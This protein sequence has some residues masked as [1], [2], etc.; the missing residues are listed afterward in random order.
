MR[1]FSGKD[2]K[3]R[4]RT[5]TTTKK[6]SESEKLT[7]RLTDLIN[8]YGKEAFFQDALLRDNNIEENYIKM[9]TTVRSQLTLFFDS[10]R[11]IDDET[12]TEQ[13]YCALLREGFNRNRILEFLSAL[14]RSVGK[15]LK[16]SSME[17]MYL[18][19]NET[20]KYSADETV[21]VDDSNI[22]EIEARVE[23]SDPNAM[24]ELGWKILC[25]KIEKYKGQRRYARELCR[26]ALNYG[27]GKAARYLGHEYVDIAEDSLISNDNYS[28]AYEYY[29]AYG[30]MSDSKYLKYSHGG[31]IKILNLGIYNRKMILN[32]VIIAV[33][34]SISFFFPRIVGLLGV[35]L[36]QSM[37]IGLCIAFSSVEFLVVIIGA[38]VRFFRP[39]FTQGWIVFLQAIIW[40]I[41]F[42]IMIV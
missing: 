25:G 10:R 40:M 30:A 29:T 34:C 17:K 12:I 6:Y 21:R 32:Y 5:K 26:T 2:Y 19:G 35:N 1:V 8:R 38:V 20:F 3:N 7:K 9:I 14:F 24:A 23:R 41:G 16:L 37:S 15:E 27:S 42:I 22:S 33:I 28:K 11:P 31:I 4:I 36:T 13:M 39:F 18:E